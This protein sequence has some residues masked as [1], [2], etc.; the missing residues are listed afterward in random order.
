MKKAAK[1]AGS[2]SSKW[3]QSTSRKDETIMT[4]MIIKAGAVAAF[5]TIPMNGKIKIDSKKRTAVVTA[6]RPV[7]P[8]AEIPAADSTYVVV[9]DV[10]NSAP[11]EVP[12]A[13]A[14]SALSILELKPVPFSRAFSS[15]SEKIP[16]LRPVPIKVPS[17]SKVSD[18]LNAKIVIKTSGRRLESAKSE[19][20]PSKAARKVVPSSAKAVPVLL[21]AKSIVDRSTTPAG[22]PATVVAIIPIK[23][24]PRTFLITKTAVKRRPNTVKRTLGSVKVEI[25]G[26]TPP[27]AKTEKTP[28]E[29][30]SA[31]AS[32]GA[33]PF[34]VIIS[35]PDV[36]K[37]IKL[38]FLKPR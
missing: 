6:V 31:V 25:P 10:P 29:N 38:E 20:R 37:V 7:R 32:A 9:F 33:T 17:V 21:F 14:K 2:A 30:V 3:L 36:K 4:P 5:G 23:I 19:D 28:F 22:I 15:S 11:I 18:K 1:K 35:E 34:T 12:I 16:V 26:T 13:S 8:P 24:A 27:P